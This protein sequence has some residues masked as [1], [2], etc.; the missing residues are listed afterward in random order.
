LEKYHKNSCSVA[1]LSF[2]EE[3]TR[4]KEWIT[5]QQE[6]KEKLA[7]VEV[8]KCWVIHSFII[9]FRKKLK[10]SLLINTRFK[11]KIELIKGAWN[12]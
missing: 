8:R 1:Q 12:G 7:L 4:K 9:I 2:E 10:G 11:M 3:V 6:Y 5:T